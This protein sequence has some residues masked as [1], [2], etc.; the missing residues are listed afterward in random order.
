MATQESTLDFSS[1]LFSVLGQWLTLSD[2]RLWLD[3]GRMH[4]S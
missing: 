3:K 4:F 2:V 1:G